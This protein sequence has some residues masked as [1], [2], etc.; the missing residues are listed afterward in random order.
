MNV[1]PMVKPAAPPA[2]GA[3]QRHPV[4]EW[5]MRRMFSPVF[6]WKDPQD[7]GARRETIPGLDRSLLSASIVPSRRAPARGVVLLCHPFLK[8]GKSYF[9]SNGYAQWLSEAGWHVVAF[10]FKGFGR[11]TLGGICFADDVKAA[12]DWAR[13]RHPGLPLHLLGT[14]FGAFHAIHAVARH[15]PMFASMVFD[16]VPMSIATFFDKGVVGMLM[17]RISSSSWARPTGTHELFESLPSIRSTPSL[18]LFGAADR[19]ISATDIE[20][21]RMLCPEAGVQC[22]E[23]CGH[24]ELRKRQGTVYAAS[25]LDFLQDPTAAAKG[26]T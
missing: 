24:L 5:L 23:A 1:S 26:R 6:G 19:Y 3:G 8:Y 18:F 13:E 15:G 2:A 22:V 17:R 20:R 4:I 9:L 14:S 11:S 21:L 7:H 25:I 16:S 10:D 12:A